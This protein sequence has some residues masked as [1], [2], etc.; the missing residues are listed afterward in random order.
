MLQRRLA[1]LLLLLSSVA[2]GVSNSC[3]AS[4]GD[5]SA[6]ARWAAEDEFMKFWFNESWITDEAV[7]EA[8]HKEMR[9]GIH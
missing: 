3:N 5:W 8:A 1:Q 7:L 6:L 9:R 2:G 4:T